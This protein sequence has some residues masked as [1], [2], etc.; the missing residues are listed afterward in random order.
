MGANRT[1][2]PAKLP[3]SPCSTRTVEASVG[4]VSKSQTGA[5][6]VACHPTVAAQRAFVILLYHPRP[7]RVT[8]FHFAPS[9]PLIS[10]SPRLVLCLP[11][12]QQLHPTV[13]VDQLS[14]N[15]HLFPT[16][17]S[18]LLHTVNMKYQLIALPALAATVAAQDL[19][20]PSRESITSQR[21]S[22]DFHPQQLHPRRA[23]DCPPQLSR[24]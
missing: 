9:I 7:R 3:L 23:P 1:K 22:T 10:S 24:R 8:S 12:P 6:R 17:H 4:A 14:F 19:Y 11:L 20:V 16:T 2:S 15:Q 13:A 21:L 5:G 18:K